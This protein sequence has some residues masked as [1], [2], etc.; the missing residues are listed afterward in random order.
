L[1]PRHDPATAAELSRIGLFGS[2][3][4]ATLSRIAASFERLEHAP[5][6]T[7]PV[8]DRFLVLLRGMAT[9]AGGMLRPGD[10]IGPD[11]GSIR[12]VTPVTVVTCDRAT[13]DEHLRPQADR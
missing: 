12:A 7:I 11:A 10:T 8:D 9:G 4:G 5:G 6:A 1:S 2:I 13:Y 3:P